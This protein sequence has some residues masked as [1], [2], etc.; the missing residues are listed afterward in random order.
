MS[1]IW[2]SV[3]N[4]N[5]SKETLED[6]KIK[7]NL[8]VPNER[9]EPVRDKVL[10]R[11]A[12][13]VSIQGF[14]PGK[15]PKNV[16]IAHLGPTLYE[17]TLNELIPKATLEV[18]QHEKLL[19]LDQI[20]YNVEKIAEGSGIKYN[21]TFTVFPEFK[22]PNMS[23]I[24]V[25]KGK[26][27]ITDDE[28]D[29]VITQMYKDQMKKEKAPKEKLKMDDT[30][31]ASL[32]LGVKNLKELRERI[33]GEL[34]RQKESMEQNKY[35]DEIV[36]QIIKKSSF[37]VPKTLMDK[38]IARKEQ[39]YKDRI[40]KLGMKLEEFLKNQKTTIEQLRKEWEETAEKQIKAEIIFMKVAKKYEISVSDK[41]LEDQ[42]KQIKDERMKAQYQ[43]VEAKRRL[44]NILLRQKIVSKILELVEGKSK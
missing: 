15:A 11:L 34:E 19:P 36:S 2:Q 37:D 38:E 13:S 31:A 44:R 29:G 41:E 18:I 39:E 32:N 12:P 6:G 14:R 35:V 8:E 3:N 24:K 7:L 23:K 5:Y 20:T 4:V 22:L 16:L 10:K 26:T 25:K 17:E 1:G 40:E 21:A 27:D 43:S 42:L 33:K 9:F 30:W 28:V